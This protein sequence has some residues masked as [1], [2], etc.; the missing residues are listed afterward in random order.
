MGTRF[1][2]KR[3]FLVLCIAF[4][5][6]AGAQILKGRDLSYSIMH[7]GLWSLIAATIFILA[8]LYQSRR[9]QHCAICK[10]TPETKNKEP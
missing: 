5:I 9:G 8:R 3:F 2:I 10:D 6:I 7:A 1:W 4:V